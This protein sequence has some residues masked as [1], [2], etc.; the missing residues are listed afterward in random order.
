MASAPRRSNG[1]LQS[2]GFRGLLSRPAGKETLLFFGILPDNTAGIDIPSSIALQRS[3]GLRNPGSPAGRRAGIPCP[4]AKGQRGCCQPCR[5]RGKSPENPAAVRASARFLCRARR[6]IS[7]VPLFFH[8]QGTRFALMVEFHNIPDFLRT[9][10]T[11]PAGR[12]VKSGQLCRG[13]RRSRKGPVLVHAGER[14]RK[15]S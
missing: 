10:R 4:L 11:E 9:R 14:R 6:I 13:R 2:F 1:R 3:H 8:G 12:G 5:C 15:K 7:V